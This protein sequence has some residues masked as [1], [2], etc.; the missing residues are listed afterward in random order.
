MYGKE[1]FNKPIPMVCQVLFLILY[2]IV[3]VIMMPV[4]FYKLY[5]C[6]VWSWAYISIYRKAA[7]FSGMMF[8]GLLYALNLFWYTLILKGVWKMVK[9][10]LGPGK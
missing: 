3:R 6:G 2:T 7:W 10:F 5:K 1:D 8:I 9:S 4:L